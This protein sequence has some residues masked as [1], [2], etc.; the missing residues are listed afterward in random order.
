[1]MSLLYVRHLRTI[2]NDI[3]VRRD[4]VSN[5]ILG[6]YH[7]LSRLW[8]ILYV[9]VENTGNAFARQKKSKKRMEDRQKITLE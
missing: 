7:Y 6:R 9:S 2:T 4:L 5:L 8:R 1:M 3:V